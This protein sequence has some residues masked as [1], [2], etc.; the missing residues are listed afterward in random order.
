VEEH[1]AAQVL[2]AEMV[3]ADHRVLPD[4]EYDLMTSPEAHPIFAELNFSE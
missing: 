3:S 4:V 1:Q 2:L